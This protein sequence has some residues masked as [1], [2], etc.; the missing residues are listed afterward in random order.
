MDDSFCIPHQ[1]AASF[2]AQR[3]AGICNQHNHY[4]RAS[5]TDHTGGCAT[6]P[7]EMVLDG[8]H[9]GLADNISRDI[10]LLPKAA[11]RISDLIQNNFSLHYGSIMEPLGW[12]THIV[13][14]RGSTWWMAGERLAI[15][16]HADE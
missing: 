11:I 8:M 16:C 2:E 1:H 4:P 3:M 12:D 13:G 9:S 5:C 6:A 7:E 15:Y 10:H 14:D